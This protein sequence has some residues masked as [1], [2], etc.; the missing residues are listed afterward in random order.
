[1]YNRRFFF[2]FLYTF[3]M[4]SL[5]LTF[6]ILIISVC[7]CGFLWVDL[8]WNSVGFLNLFLN[9]PPADREVSSGS[10]SGPFFLSSLSGAPIM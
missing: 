5:P 8:I 10:F 6:T 1:M 9:L 7:H 2:F 3:K 4:L